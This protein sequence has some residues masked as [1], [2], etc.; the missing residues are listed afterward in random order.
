MHALLERRRVPK[1]G[2]GRSDVPSLIKFI[3]NKL[4]SRRS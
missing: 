4:Q 1:D 3:A 2:D